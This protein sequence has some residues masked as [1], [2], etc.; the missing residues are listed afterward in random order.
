MPVWWT[1]WALG[2]QDRLTMLGKPG[3]PTASRLA[4][5]GARRNQLG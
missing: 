4:E 5:R 1:G 3:L 2:R